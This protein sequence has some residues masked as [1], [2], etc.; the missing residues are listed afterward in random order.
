[1]KREN[2][3]QK[4]MTANE[5]PGFLKEHFDIETRIGMGMVESVNV[6]SLSIPENS[7]VDAR[8]LEPKEESGIKDEDDCDAHASTKRALRVESTVN[9]KGE[10]AREGEGKFAFVVLHHRSD[11][12]KYWKVVGEK[13]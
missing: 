9:H 10:P 1:M 4:I 6:E 3:V 7:E 8:M 13:V 2:K 5:V 11:S 12:N